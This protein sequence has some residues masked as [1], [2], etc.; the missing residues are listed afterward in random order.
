MLLLLT[1]ALLVG[2]TLATATLAGGFIECAFVGLP[3]WR[4]LG[5]EAWA[6]GLG[7]SLGRVQRHADLGN[8]LVIY[9]FAAIFGAVL[10]LVIDQFSL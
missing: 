2:A 4:Q 8:G 5:P 10:T 7:P 1:R 9:P 3:A 6:Q